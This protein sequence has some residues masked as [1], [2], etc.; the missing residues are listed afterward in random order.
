[1]VN[2]PYTKGNESFSSKRATAKP[3]KN[4]VK[5]EKELKQNRMTATHLPNSEVVVDKG[6][7]KTSVGKKTISQGTQTKSTEM[8]RI[9]NI[10]RTLTDDKLPYWSIVSINGYYLDAG[11]WKLQ[12]APT[13]Y[14]LVESTDHWDDQDAVTI[15]NDQTYYTSVLSVEC[16]WLDPTKKWN[17]DTRG[18]DGPYLRAVTTRKF[19]STRL[20]TCERFYEVVREM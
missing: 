1:M 4:S 9:E 2:A 15:S 18:H 10:N 8:M 16:E 19:R 14:G 3:K 6:I 13:I 17:K 11:C 5:L 12:N 20:R 7:S